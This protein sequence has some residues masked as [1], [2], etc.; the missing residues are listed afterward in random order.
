MESL[1][2]L[3]V[4]G[5]E[6]RCTADLR[7]SPGCVEWR[8]RFPFALS[9]LAYRT[10]ANMP[11]RRTGQLGFSTRFAR[12]QPLFI[13]SPATVSSFA[14]I[15]H[16]RSCS[17]SMRSTKCFPMWQ[18]EQTSLKDSRGVESGRRLPTCPRSSGCSFCG[19]VYVR[20]TRVAADI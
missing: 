15:G 8:A 19:I 4:K 5:A 3:E 9:T 20:R 7:T 17:A 6:S 14:N 11:S 10:R 16:K 2:G 1:P 18:G 13:L 12:P